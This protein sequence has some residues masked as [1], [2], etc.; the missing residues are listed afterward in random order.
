MG[1]TSRVKGGP[2]PFRAS[3]GRLHASG[4]TPPSLPPRMPLRHPECLNAQNAFMTAFMTAFMPRMPLCTF[5]QARLRPVSR[6]SRSLPPT[7]THARLATG[8]ALPP[9]GAQTPPAG[10]LTPCRH[11]RPH[12]STAR[13]RP[14]TRPPCTPRPP[15]TPLRAQPPRPPPPPT[16]TLT[17]HPTSTETP[18][19]HQAPGA[20]RCRRMSVRDTTPHGTRRGPSSTTYTLRVCECVQGL[21]PK[22]LK[23]STLKPNPPS[24]TPCGRACVLACVRVFVRVCSAAEWG[25]GKQEWQGLRGAAGR[26]AALRS[27]NGARS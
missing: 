13:T 9:S 12:S 22:T 10:S 2:P 5:G 24:S 4:T 3:R 18:P 21:G 26:G 11:P 1:S 20:Q 23:P 16:P 19:P 8:Y 17:L 15:P 25:G 7:P 27:D 14:L 6:P